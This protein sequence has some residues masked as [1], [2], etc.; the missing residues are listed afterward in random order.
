MENTLQKKWY[1]IKVQNNRERTVSQRLQTEMSREFKEELNIIIPS[2]GIVTLKDGKNKTREKLLY[3]GYIFVETDNIEKVG[4]LVKQTDGATS[5][6]KDDK[7][8]PAFLREHE[9]HKM[10][11]QREEVI[12]LKTNSFRVG[13]KVTIQSG[14]FSGFNGFVDFVEKDR[15]RVDVSIFGRITKVDMTSAEITR[16][17]EK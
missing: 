14:P 15:I 8:N 7:G 9:V 13:E 16:Y 11:E 17:Q 5:I 1:T 6:L 4:H 10:I 12:D 3:P 2:M